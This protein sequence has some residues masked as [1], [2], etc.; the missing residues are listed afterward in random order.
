MR[1][2]NVMSLLFG[3]LFTA[4]ALTYALWGVNFEA[5]FKAF[6]EIDYLAVL[7]FLF[8]L[9][10]FFWLKATR[11]TV[12]LQPIG[13]FTSRQ[14][15]PAMMIGF[16][17]NNVLPARLGELLRTVVFARRF[18]KPYSG[19]FATVML[20][21]LLDASAI[22]IFYVITILLLGTSPTAVRIGALVGLAFIIVALAAIFLM[23]WRF[24]LT[25]SLWRRISTRLPQR[26]RELG[27]KLLHNVTEALSTLRSPRLV[28]LLIANSLCQWSI[29]TCNVWIAM[30]AFGATI[31]ISA[32][33]FVLVV[34]ALAASVPSIPGYVG[35]IQAAFV[36]ALSPFGIAQETALA[37]SVF[38]LVVQWVPVTAAGV[39][40]FFLSGFGVAEVRRE[41][42]WV[43]R[44]PEPNENE[45]TS[46]R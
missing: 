22:L 29:M 43:E 23:L 14:V 32:A 41:A 15:T 39:L 30:W 28:T 6:S 24:H 10:V 7:P 44:S 37:G 8:L 38:F 25:L 5:L 2:R 36:F 21:R 17:G 31:S 19:V 16:A 3:A 9:I 45:Q 46:Y 12:I 18:D 33:I 1:I 34:T 4:L 40:F 20:E 11:W 35:P 26:Y 13:C 27:E 42:Q